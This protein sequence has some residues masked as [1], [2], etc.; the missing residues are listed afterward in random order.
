MSRDLSYETD[1]GPKTKHEFH[2]IVS[3]CLHY[4][5][6]FWGYGILSMLN[7]GMILQ[8][9]LQ[10]YETLQRTSEKLES[11]K[12]DLQKDQIRM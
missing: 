5:F 10:L 1:S 2:I 8:Q 11:E 6:Y 7:T 12:S 9:V 4:F 3:L